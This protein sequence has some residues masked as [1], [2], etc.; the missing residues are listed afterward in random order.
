MFRTL[1]ESVNKLETTKMNSTLS[2]NK[3]GCASE[4]EW[5]AIDI[6][7]LTNKNFQEVKDQLDELVN[8]YGDTIKIFEE[9]L[10]KTHVEL[11]SALEKIKQYEHNETSLTDNNKIIKDK[12]KYHPKE[13]SNSEKNYVTLTP[14]D[15]EKKVKFLTTSNVQKPEVEVKGG[16]IMGEAC[17]TEQVVYQKGSSTSIDSGTYV[18]STGLASPTSPGPS[19]SSSWY[20]LND[21]PQSAGSFA[22][23]DDSITRRRY[24]SAPSASS[25]RLSTDANFD[26]SNAIVDETFRYLK[27]DLKEI[28]TQL[29]DF[30]LEKLDRILPG[31]IHSIV[32][33]YKSLNESINTND[34][35]EIITTCARK[36]VEETCITC[37]LADEQNTSKHNYVVAALKNKLIGF[38]LQVADYETEILDAAGKII[39]EVLKETNIKQALATA[40]DSGRTS[41]ESLITGLNNQ[42]TAQ[43]N[44]QIGPAILEY[45]LTKS[46]DYLSSILNALMLGKSKLSDTELQALLHQNSALQYAANERDFSLL[47]S[48]IY[49]AADYLRVPYPADFTVSN[50]LFLRARQLL[51]SQALERIKNQYHESCED[52]IDADAKD[53]NTSTA[54]QWLKEKCRLISGK[55]FN[56]TLNKEEQK[57]FNRQYLGLFYLSDLNLAA[58]A[59]AS[60]D[61]LDKELKNLADSDLKLVTEGHRHLL[62]IENKFSAY[63]ELTN[64]EVFK[65][66]LNNKLLGN[67]NNGEFQVS[68]EQAKALLQGIS[69]H[70]ACNISGQRELTTPP[71][72]RKIYRAIQPA[73]GYSTANSNLSGPKTENLICIAIKLL[74]SHH[75]LEKQ[76]QKREKWKQYIKRRYAL[77]EHIQAARSAVAHRVGI[78]KK[79]MQIKK[80]SKLLKSTAN[81]GPGSVLVPSPYCI[82]DSPEEY[83]LSSTDAFFNRR[84]PLKLG[85]RINYQQELGHKKFAM[86]SITRNGENSLAYHTKTAWNR[87]LG[88]ET[89][90]QL[91]FSQMIDALNSFKDSEIIRFHFSQCCPKAAE[92]QYRLFISVYN[93]LQQESGKGPLLYCMPSNT[94]KITKFELTAARTEIEE[95]LDLYANEHKAINNKLSASYGRGRG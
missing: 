15:K 9:A 23:A 60:I 11:T 66:N 14:G 19:E 35:S 32:A 53:I 51:R 93:E 17:S 13:D 27:I 75:D 83:Y 74:F 40:V 8:G 41:D 65:A 3:E 95:K 61:Q 80:E 69:R 1:N 29:D 56:L 90:K 22:D 46:T 4:S 36:I 45:V 18:S 50:E 82:V 33:C 58:V 87:Q 38:N 71:S 67:K 70:I 20:Y 5:G 68:T 77:I 39:S 73:F 57:R 7:S 89:Q 26:L 86:W 84:K 48:A 52:A 94:L 79:G 2:D 43:I 63:P 30:F 6:D 81:S 92:K 44:Q 72:V 85:Q 49:P 76:L 28:F 31:E 34:L 37:F 62:A 10:G 59:H 16:K 47:L 24:S 91:T 54:K 64:L 55:S 12:L 42:L 78:L 88:E 25:P 21:C